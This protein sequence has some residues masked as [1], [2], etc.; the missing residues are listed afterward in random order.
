MSVAGSPNQVGA[1]MCNESPF[2]LQVFGVLRPG[3]VSSVGPERRAAPAEGEGG[4]SD[5]NSCGMCRTNPSLKT[6]SEKTF[7]FLLDLPEVF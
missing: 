6:F 3:E 2:L 5:C 1:A 7:N 4:F